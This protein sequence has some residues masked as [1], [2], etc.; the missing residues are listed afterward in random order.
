MQTSQVAA[1]TAE[2]AMQALDDH[3]FT[4]AELA[5]RW[6]THESTLANQRSQG[7][8]IPFHKPQGKVL[9]RM[10]DVIRHELDKR[11]ETGLPRVFELIGSFAGLDTAGRERLVRHIKSGLHAAV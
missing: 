6:R 1:N 2:L 9:Y 7:M 11:V 4:P 10:S 3:F 5:A 8:G